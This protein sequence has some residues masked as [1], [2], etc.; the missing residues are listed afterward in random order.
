M[1]TLD[2]YLI[3][4]VRFQIFQQEEIRV[5]VNERSCAWNPGGW[6]TITKLDEPEMTF[7]LE[8]SNNQ[9]AQKSCLKP[10]KYPSIKSKS[11]I[12]L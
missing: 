11:K 2:K 4:S 1:S 8:L 3:F 12:I 7:S 5:S 6:R 9:M 10:D